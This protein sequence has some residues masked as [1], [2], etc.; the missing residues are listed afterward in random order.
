M[1][2][3][4]LGWRSKDEVWL[5]FGRERQQRGSRHASQLAVTG[6]DID[7]A[8]GDRGTGGVDR[9]S[10][11]LHAVQGVIGSQRIEVPKRFATGSAIGAQVAVHGTGKHNVRDHGDWRHLSG[12]ATGLSKTW[13]TGRSRVPDFF[14]GRNS[15]GEQ[16]AT[17]FRFGAV[18]IRE[19][20]IDGL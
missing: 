14:A 4:G 18:D 15:D 12:G 16:T 6:I 3:Y 17:L 9:A 13:R 2:R 7:H 10:S 8:T 19:R 1:C 5:V 11:G 20:C